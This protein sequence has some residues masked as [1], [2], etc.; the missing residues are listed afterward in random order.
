M[1]R[2]LILY[3]TATAVL[4]LVMFTGYKREKDIGDHVR[5]LHARC[6]RY[7]QAF[8]VLFDGEGGVF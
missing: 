8:E 2:N 4:G 1:K 5:W 7:D 3:A 6:D